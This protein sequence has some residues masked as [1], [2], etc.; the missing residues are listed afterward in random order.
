MAQSAALNIRP[1]VSLKALNTLFLPGVAARYAEI[2]VEAQLADD[3]LREQSRLILGAGSNLVLLGDFEGLVLRMGL[4]GRECIAED[5]GAWYIEAAAGEPWH[6]FVMWTIGQGWHG[7]ENLSLIPGTVGAAPIQNIGAYGLEVGSRIHEVRCWDFETQARIRLTQ[8]DCLFAY[9]N[10]LFK[11]EGWHLTGRMVVLSVVFRLPKLWCPQLHYPSLAAA[12]STQDPK[13]LT[14][15]QLAEAVMAIRREKLPD[16][17]ELP[18]AGSF[19]ENPVLPMGMSERFCTEHPD[20]PCYPQAEGG[21]KVA[22]G[23]LI[24]KAGWKGKRLGPVGMHQH[25]SLVLVNHGGALGSDVLCLMRAVQ[26]SV[27]EKFG[28]QL[29]PEPVFVGR[30]QG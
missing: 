1:A 21:V 12:L 13:N 7:L 17:A 19:F 9:R 23:W 20:A 28:I 15:L 6:E 16:P 25:Q 5:D 22:A 30:Q 24:E 26:A 8:A 4:V 27:L 10:S 11:R 29:V 14:P 18:N 3:R 2:S